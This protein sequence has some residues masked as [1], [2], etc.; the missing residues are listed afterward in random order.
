MTSARRVLPLVAAGLVAAATAPAQY[1]GRNKVQYETFDFKVLSTEHFAVY[2]Y[3]AERDA[4]EQA[5]RLAE[6]W[7]AR[8]AAVLQHRLSGRQ[9]LILYADHP[10]FEQTNVFSDQPSE[11]TGGVTESLKRR[12]ILP[13]G[14]AL[15]ET[16]HVLGHELVHAF[17]YDITGKGG[18]GSAGVPGVSRLPLWFV[19]G[20]AEYL[21]LGAADPHTAMWMRDAVHRNRLPSLSD[22]AGYKFFPYRYGQAFWAYLGGTY[23]DSIVGR[24]LRLAGKSGDVRSALQ[25]LTGRAPDSLVA[26]WHLALRAAAEPVALATGWPLPPPGAPKRRG[27]TQGPEP[28]VP[29]AR[30][31]VGGRRDTRL[32]LA[33][34]LSP[35]GRRIVYFSEASL[36]SIDLYVADAETGQSRR[37]LFSMTRD[38]HYESL[39]FINSAGAWELAGRRFAFGAIARGHPVLTIIDAETRAVEREVPFPELGEIFNPTWA[40]DGEAIAFSAQ[41]GGFTD[42]FVYDLERR[43]L[44]RLTE[45]PYADLQP[46]WAPSGG[47]IAFVTD[48]FTTSLGTLA[49][50][51]YGLAVVD[52]ASGRIRAL[53]TL[54]DAK[55]INPQ[56]SPDAL[57]LYFL[58]DRGGITNVYRLTLADGAVAQ[59]TNLYT[60]VSG[61]TALS[62]ALSVAQ[63]SGRLVFGTYQDDGYVLD[64][65]DDRRLVAGGPPRALPPRAAVLPPADQVRTSALAAMLRDPVTGLPPNTEYPVTPYR[66]GVA[67][68]FIAQPSLG[69]AADRF[70]TYIGG[71]ATLYWSDLLGDHNLVTMAQVSGE[72]GDLN[73]A[74]L[75][76]YENRKRRL[77]WGMAVQQI[78]YITGAIAA[79]TGTVGGQPAYI[80]QIDRLRQTNR[81]AVGYVAYPLNRAQRVE[82]QAAVQHI[83][84]DR[85]LRTRA[86]SL[87]T[88]REIYDST[89]RLPVADPLT[90]GSASTAVVYDNSVFGATS[91]IYGQRYR[92]EASPTFGSLQYTTLLA[93]YRRYVLPVRPFTLA[94]RVLHLGRYGPDGDDGRMYPFYLGYPSL[95]RGYDFGSFDASECPTGTGVGCPVIEQLFGSRILVGNVELRFPLFGLLGLGDGYYGFLPVE[96]A[97]FSDAGVAWTGGAG[98][99]AKLFGTGSRRLVTSAGVSLRMNLFGYAIGALDYVRAY[100]RPDTGWM[101]RLSLTPGF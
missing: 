45:D 60:G 6:R 66:A 100:D 67:L 90:L 25:Q 28:A 68:D 26:D 14:A 87:T 95:V 70:G 59:V 7:Y 4:A 11:G 84:F 23:G 93:D 18:G 3:P 79:G 75:V 71:G 38:P 20:M 12:I 86:I 30:R 29:G 31:I 17:Q 53:P 99:G 61:I 5:A 89:K 76:A 22:L 2:F 65:L 94:G 52:A 27:A 48:R 49:P 37:K 15:A 77:N 13:L 101:I 83:S 8:L 82:F 16:D 32:N 40:P 46:A 43:R 88:E 54:G 42:L 57:S 50:G 33:P 19:E 92:L 10:D 51:N 91:P 24:A 85:T 39:Q 58:A 80:E 98:G 41:V 69:I 78:P 21:S 73:V 72:F 44:R 74:G 63:R 64:A 55:H 47:A 34:A 96:A 62:P 56:W 35:D 97:L 81:Q 1:F 36:F 9:P